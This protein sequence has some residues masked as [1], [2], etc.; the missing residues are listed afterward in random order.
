MFVLNLSELF[1]NQILIKLRKDLPNQQQLPESRIQ[2]VIDGQQSKIEDY[3]VFKS[4]NDKW[5]SGSDYK[6]KTLFEDMLFLDR[7]SRNVGDILY[8][9]I[10]TMKD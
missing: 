5:I 4:L 10:F 2:S 3:E 8:L 7:A 6:T 1:L 9:D